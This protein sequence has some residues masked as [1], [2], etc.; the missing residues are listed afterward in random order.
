[1]ALTPTQLNAHLR[2]IVIQHFTDIEQDLIRFLETCRDYALAGGVDERE[3]A[4][5]IAREALQRA[6]GRNLTVGDIHIL[7]GHRIRSGG[8][9]L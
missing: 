3:A 4:R 8:D 2:A 5:I 6:L 1:M 7:Q 9:V